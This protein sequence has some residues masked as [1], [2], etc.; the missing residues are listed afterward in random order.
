IAALAERSRRRAS[1]DF[2]QLAESATD[3]IR[4]HEPDG[5]TIYVTPSCFRLL[6]FTPE[7]MLAMEPVSGLAHPDDVERLQ[8]LLASLTTPPRDSG[9]LKVTHRIRCK[10]GEHRWF[11]TQVHRV[12]D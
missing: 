5:R 4:I 12:F 7:E 6:G 3:L 1:Q 8:T 11:D 2:R 10:T 9:A